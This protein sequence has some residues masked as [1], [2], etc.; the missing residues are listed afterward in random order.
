MNTEPTP[1]PDSLG[2]PSC[3]ASLVVNTACRAN[4][5]ENDEQE[6]APCPHCGSLKDPWFS[7]VLPMSYHCQD[8]GK[9]WDSI[10][11]NPLHNKEDQER[12][13]PASEGSKFNNPNEQ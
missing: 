7:R 13:S 6:C 10:P 4:T 5:A 8:C 2:S 11:E 1:P 12:K 3:C 9:D